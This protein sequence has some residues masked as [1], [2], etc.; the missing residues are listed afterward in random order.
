MSSNDMPAECKR[1]INSATQSPTQGTYLSTIRS[2]QE[3]EAAAA[4]LKQ[5]EEEANAVGDGLIADLDED[6]QNM[7]KLSAV[8]AGDANNN[9][10]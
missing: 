2:K 3:A 5:E 8:F 7:K 9:I 4:R 1:V 6:E 10:K